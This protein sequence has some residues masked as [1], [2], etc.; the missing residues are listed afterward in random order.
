MEAVGKALALIFSFDAGVYGII[1][2]TLLV[3]IMSTGIASALAIPCGL[4]LGANA[5]R[6][7]KALV[8]VL[9]TLM[10]MPSVVVGL[11]VYL[12]LSRRGP[13]GSFSLLFTPAAMVIAQI[14]LILPLIA[15]LTCAAVSGKTDEVL[16]TC[17]GLGIPKKRAKVL[18]AHECRHTLYTSALAGYGRAVSEVGAVMLV[19]GNIQFKTRVM[20]TA[21]VLETNK[22]NYE[23]ALA[24]GTILLLIVFVVN[25]VS[26][27]FFRS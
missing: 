6:G 20:T 18:L 1:G 10:G 21:I 8:S 4:F 24:L 7:R 14:L 27:R 9:N 17:M 23:V 22:G 2:R 26:R 13:L 12:I 11:I 3:T 16:S 15:S 5:F 25:A 19:G